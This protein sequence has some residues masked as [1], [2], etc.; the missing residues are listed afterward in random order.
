MGLKA[1]GETAKS[2]PGCK[3]SVSARKGEIRKV[4]S[5]ERGGND[6]PRYMTVSPQGQTEPGLSVCLPK[7]PSGRF[8]FGART[9]YIPAA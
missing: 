6:T 5:L 2:L 3:I 1:W 9:C 7:R 4:R 8:A